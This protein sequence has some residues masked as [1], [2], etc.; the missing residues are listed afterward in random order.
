VLAGGISSRMGR[1]KLELEVSGVPLLTRVVN[2]LATVCEEVL[3]AGGREDPRCRTVPDLR[4]ERMG[5]LAGIEAGLDGA[6]HRQVFVAAGD[7][8]FLPEELVRFLLE[9]LGEGVIAVVPHR[10]EGSHP[11]CAAYDRR[12]LPLVSCALD[13]GV[14]S[15]RGFLDRLDGVRYVESEL[16]YFGDPERLL[17]NVNSPSDLRAALREA[18]E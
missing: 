12:I 4:P 8:P 1:D 2:V 7:M 18:G 17:L 15:V 5:P 3:L 14:R 11:L 13:E 10:G 9:G 16:S 6:K